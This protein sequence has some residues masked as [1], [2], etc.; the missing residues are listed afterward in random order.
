MKPIDS[1]M[2]GLED[3]NKVVLNKV[4][5]LVNCEVERI[6]TERDNEYNYMQYGQLMSAQKILF[7]LE[8]L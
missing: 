3:G 8:E 4:I 1:Y 7:E 5:E 2:K 6:Q